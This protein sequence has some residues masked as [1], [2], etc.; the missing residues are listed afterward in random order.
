M[1]TL[2]EVAE[3]AEDALGNELDFAATYTDGAFKWTNG[4]SMFMTGDAFV[5]EAD[6]SMWFYSQFTAGF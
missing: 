3:D 1:F 5:D 4:L 2:V 6:N